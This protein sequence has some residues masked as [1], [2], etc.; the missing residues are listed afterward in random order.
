MAQGLTDL[1]LAKHRE[2][3]AAIADA[4]ARRVQI[5]RLGDRCDVWIIVD[6]HKRRDEPTEKIESS[7]RGRT[8][9]T[10]ARPVTVALL[11]LCSTAFAPASG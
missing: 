10:R 11:R 5:E 6:G 4:R 1:C 7:G 3:D 2:K 9:V 8:T